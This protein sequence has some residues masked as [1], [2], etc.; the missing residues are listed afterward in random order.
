MRA[1]LLDFGNVVGY[2]DHR[3]ACR[4]LAELSRTAM[5]ED[6][7]YRTVFESPLEPDVDRG[8]VSTAAFVALL[9]EHLHLDAADDAIARAWCDI[10]EPNVDLIAQLPALKARAGRLVLASNTN[11]LHFSWIRRQFADALGWFDACVVSYE[12]GVLKPDRAFFEH[13]A[14]VA[15][16]APAACVFVD[17][18]P[19][20]VDAARHLGMAGVVYTPGL[21][22]LAAVERATPGGRP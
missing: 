3:R 15:G 7:V 1:L 21:D 17:D 11:E 10:F 22:L 12:A 20:F 18:K 6:E 8:L 2:F 19:A 5:T 16:Q 9:R 4:Q 14:R 13:C